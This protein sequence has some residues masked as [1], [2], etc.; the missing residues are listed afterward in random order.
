[1]LGPRYWGMSATRVG[2]ENAIESSWFKCSWN[3]R[4][5]VTASPAS[6]FLRITLADID[7]ISAIPS[8]KRQPTVSAAITST[9]V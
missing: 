8:S 7:A 5:A 4:E 3:L 1:M 2:S 6:T 9:K